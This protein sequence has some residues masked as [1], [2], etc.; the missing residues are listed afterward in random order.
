MFTKS[1]NQKHVWSSKGN[2]TTV[3][4][5]DYYSEY[6]ATVAAISKEL[7]NEVIYTH[8]RPI[9]QE[10]FISF[11]R[12]LRKRNAN[13]KLIIFMDNLYVHKTRNVLSEMESLNIKPVFNAVYSPQFNPI[14]SA[15]AKVKLLFK[16]DKLNRLVHGK[17]IDRNSMIRSAFSK[18]TRENI[19]NYIEHSFKLLTEAIRL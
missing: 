15:F 12:L 4:G 14:E 8:E 17:P 10:Q 3:G 9:K 16:K 18:L 6:T 7:G 2:N 13:H 11:L 19:R 5:K 1:T